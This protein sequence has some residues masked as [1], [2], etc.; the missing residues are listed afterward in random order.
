MMIVK[1]MPDEPSLSTN[2]EAKSY[3]V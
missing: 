2:A 3:L 1:N